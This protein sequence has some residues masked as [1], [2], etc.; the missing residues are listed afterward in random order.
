VLVLAKALGGG[1]PLGAFIASKEIM[2]TLAFQPELGHIT[3][4]GGHPVCCAA[5]LASLEVL[6]GD[7]LISDADKKGAI[8]E[9][10]LM[11]HPLV[12]EIR[13]K[14]LMIGVE[15]KDKSKRNRLTEVMLKNGVIIDWF[16]FHPCTFRIAP[17]LTITEEECFCA[18]ELLIKAMN[19]I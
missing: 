16:L 8:F 4:F 15:I 5:A 7:D 3:T 1:M 17:P 2:D 19:E 13:R 9:D 12:K 14:G 10:Q 6:L 18:I 11:T